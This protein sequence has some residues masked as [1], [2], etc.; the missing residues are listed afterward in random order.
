MG[1]YS[2]DEWPEQADASWPRGCLIENVA[3]HP[4]RPWIALVATNPEDEGGAVMVLDA[5]TGRVRS[6]TL[7][8]TIL[9]WC[10][11]ADLLR[12]HPDGR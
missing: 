7:Y 10:E 3:V 11:Q 9:G 6:T 8:P 2:P 4:S 12:W 1:T 5:T